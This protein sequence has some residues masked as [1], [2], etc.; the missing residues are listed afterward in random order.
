MPTAGSLQHPWKG[1]NG[2]YL[3]SFPVVQDWPFG[4]A[5]DINEEGA[6]VCLLTSCMTGRARCKCA[7]SRVHAVQACTG[8]FKGK[9]T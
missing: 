8:W 1:F 7:F 4:F 5:F 3:S 6:S 2:L 9:L